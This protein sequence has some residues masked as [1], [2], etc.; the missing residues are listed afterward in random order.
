[1]RSTGSS[2]HSCFYYYFEGWKLWNT[3]MSVAYFHA[4]HS[5]LSFIRWL[6]MPP[7]R[8]KIQ[9]GLCQD[10]FLD[11]TGCRP[12]AAQAAQAAQRSDQWEHLGGCLWPRSSVI[13]WVW[14]CLE[15]SGTPRCLGHQTFKSFNQSWVMGRH[16]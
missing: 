13:R 4:S 1:M 7:W 5:I 3:P 16:V 2:Q 10:F 11:W 15:M 12:Q 8:P 9:A 14:K 6:R